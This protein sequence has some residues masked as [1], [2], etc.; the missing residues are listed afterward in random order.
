MYY[1]RQG[2]SIDMITWA[3]L[4]GDPDYRQIERT[5]IPGPEGERDST[6]STVW[7]GMDHAF[8]GPKQIFE[9][10]VFDGRLDGEMDRYSTMIGARFG[11]SEM[12]KRVHAANE[13]CPGANQPCPRCQKWHED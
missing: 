3:K 11:H 9:T 12:V 2:N 6:V 4:H 8:E 13:K 7:L 5:V 10:L 1:D